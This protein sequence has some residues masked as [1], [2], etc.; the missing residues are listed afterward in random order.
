MNG[1]Y[2]SLGHLKE[3]QIYSRPREALAGGACVDMYAPWVPVKGTGGSGVG[4]RW[5]D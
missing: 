4:R 5:T 2:G 3:V 1:A